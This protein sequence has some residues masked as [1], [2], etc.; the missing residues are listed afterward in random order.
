MN[1]FNKSEIETIW[2]LFRQLQ[3]PDSTITLRLERDN[4]KGNDLNI[5][6]LDIKE[7][8]LIIERRWMVGQ[9]MD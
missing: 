1:Q 4:W 2:N 5:T 3:G 6:F 8:H 9:Q 7:A